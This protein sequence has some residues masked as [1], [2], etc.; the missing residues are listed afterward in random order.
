VPT[1]QLSESGL[2]LSSAP[3]HGQDERINWMKKYK[4]FCCSSTFAFILSAMI[5]QPDDPMNMV[6]HYHERIQPCPREMIRDLAPALLHV[7]TD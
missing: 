5:T 4:L 6:R 2:V 7:C 1:L 3:K